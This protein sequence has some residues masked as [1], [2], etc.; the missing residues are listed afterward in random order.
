MFR[1]R[2]QQ[3]ASA[4]V[5]PSRDDVSSINAF[6]APAQGDGDY[7]VVV[8]QGSPLA[9]AYAAYDQFRERGDVASLRAASRSSRSD[10][11]SASASLSFSP[12]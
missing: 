4:P 12:W 2:K 1:R 8:R 5:G 3:D 7:T 11:D 6:L 10:A 9:V